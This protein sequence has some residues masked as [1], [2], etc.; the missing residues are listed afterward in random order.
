MNQ[1]GCYRGTFRSQRQRDSIHFGCAASQS[2]AYCSPRITQARGERSPIGRCS[3][4]EAGADCK[5]NTSTSAV[6]GKSFGGKA[7]AEETAYPY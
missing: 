5:Q 7:G 3:V 1:T 2:N 4:Q 6:I